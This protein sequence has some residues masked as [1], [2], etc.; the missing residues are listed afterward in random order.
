MMISCSTA[1][2]VVLYSARIYFQEKNVTQVQ[3]VFEEYKSLLKIQSYFE[4]THTVSNIRYT[5][6]I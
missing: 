5:R 4:M 1:T 2:C 6:D 3:L